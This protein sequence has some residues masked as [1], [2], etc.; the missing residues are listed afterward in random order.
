MKFR[1]GIE[2]RDDKSGNKLPLGSVVPGR[3]LLERRTGYYHVFTL[4]IH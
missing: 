4:K 1:I 3:G 2:V